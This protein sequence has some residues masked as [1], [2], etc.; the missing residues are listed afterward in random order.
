MYGMAST[1]GESSTD[2]AFTGLIEAIDHPVVITNSSGEIVLANTRAGEIASSSTGGWKGRL[3]PE[4]FDVHERA[5]LAAQL[6]DTQT[7]CRPSMSRYR[8]NHA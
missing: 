5:E 1:L 2:S 8:L 6:A 7:R 3:F 4:S